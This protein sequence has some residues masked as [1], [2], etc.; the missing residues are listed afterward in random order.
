VGE[1]CQAI[2][3]NHLKKGHTRIGYG[4]SDQRDVFVDP[5]IAASGMGAL[6]FSYKIVNQVL[7]HKQGATDQFN[8]C[9]VR[10]AWTHCDKRQ[11]SRELTTAYRNGRG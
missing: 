7:E 11:A 6:Q 4:S 1:H 10:D 3:G 9:G 2:R 5:L 8:S